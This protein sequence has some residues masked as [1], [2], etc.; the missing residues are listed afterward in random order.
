MNDVR[1]DV[2]KTVPRSASFAARKGGKKE[3]LSYSYSHEGSLVSFLDGIRADNITRRGGGGGGGGGGG[4][5]YWGGGGDS[6]TSPHQ[7]GAHLHAR[8]RRRR[9]LSAIRRPPKPRER[10]REREG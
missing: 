2:L 6:L 5:N 4:R 10:E 3:R 8:E 1:S 7:S 9:L